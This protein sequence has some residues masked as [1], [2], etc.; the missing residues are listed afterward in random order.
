M[1]KLLGDTPSKLVVVSIEDILGIA[2]Q[3]NI[4]GTVDEHPNW[5]QRLPVNVEELPAARRCGRSGRFSEKQG[6]SPHPL[7]TAWKAEM[8]AF[9]RK[10]QELRKDLVSARVHMTGR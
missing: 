6:V 10:N 5:R 4:P 3:P 2:D 7:L 9:S 1:A 8:A